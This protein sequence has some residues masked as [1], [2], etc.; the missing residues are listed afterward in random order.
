[1]PEA[2]CAATFKVWTKF[3]TQKFYSLMLATDHRY[4]CLMRF[5]ILC[6]RRN[7]NSKSKWVCIQL[8]LSEIEKT[9][10]KLQASHWMVSFLLLI[11]LNMIY[12]LHVS[13][14]WNIKCIVH[15]WITCMITFS[16]NPKSCPNY[17]KSIWNWNCGHLGGIFII[18]SLK[19]A[20]VN[21]TGN[22]I[23][24]TVYMMF[25]IQFS[26]NILVTEKTENLVI[27]IAK[28]VSKA[29]RH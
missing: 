24:N 28:C 13:S 21:S 6:C 8:S 1:M 3:N 11:M 22:M 2:T 29:Q 7:N 19:S 4:E 23:F 5:L 18:R 12:Y 20:Y 25:R 17:A 9:D 15:V 10:N 27:V 14:T 16:W 26:R